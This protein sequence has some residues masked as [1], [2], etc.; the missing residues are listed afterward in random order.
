M[1]VGWAD[2]GDHVAVYTNIESVCRTTETNRIS[3]VNFTSIKKKT[4]HLTVDDKI[5]IFVL[6]LLEKD[7]YIRETF[8]P[9]LSLRGDFEKKCIWH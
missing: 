1:I 6:T 7:I 5:S 9:D 2:C 4:W 3:Y 8:P